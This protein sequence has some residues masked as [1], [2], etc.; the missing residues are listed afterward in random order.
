MSDADRL[1]EHLSATAEL[2]VE[3]TASRLLGE[4]EAV[5]G[6]LRTADPD[7]Q[8]ERAAVVLELL[9]EVE[10]TGNEEADEHVERARSLAAELADG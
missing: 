2:P 7:V 9:E 3:R 8:A 10:E 1:H 6:D 4:A 5:A